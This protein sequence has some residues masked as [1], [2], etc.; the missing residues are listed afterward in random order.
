MT[1]SQSKGNGDDEQSDKGKAPTVYS[2]SF[3]DELFRRGILDQEF[4]NGGI[5]YDKPSNYD[6]IRDAI[7]A[8]RLDDVP[9]EADHREFVE[10]LWET[11][12]EAEKR[13]VYEMF[14]GIPK[15]LRKPHRK[16]LEGKWV[17]HIPI[18]GELARKD[19]KQKPHPDA[20]E[21]LQAL[22]IPQWILK[23][24]H[25][26]AVPRSRF[27]FPNFVVEL[28][29][30]KSMF[31]AHVQSRHCG[32]AA[33]QGFVEFYL[34]LGDAA[35]AWDT[36]KVGSIEFNGD[37]VVGNIHWATKSDVEPKGRKYHMTKAMCHFT[38]GLSF[39]QFKLARRE[40]RNF[41]DYFLKERENFQQR[42]N[43]L[44]ERPVEV[45]P[46]VDED[47]EVA[48][49]SNDATDE[50]DGAGQEIHYSFAEPLE[51]T[52]G[53]NSFLEVP[54]NGPPRSR[55]AARAPGKRAKGTGGRP[56][57]RT[58]GAEEKQNVGSRK[59]GGR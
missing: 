2:Q 10:T 43:S 9:S 6:T 36:A 31:T 38:H 48:D 41:R 53:E 26:Y 5:E 34:R 24:L 59:K 40:A 49:D 51:G 21:G 55:S 39:E 29:R 1:K 46:S 56:S 12:N 16:S 7:S 25:G 19:C 57:K 3:L 33:M 23:R 52:L 4:Q 18:T 50:E 8:E 32:A 58:K 28:K 14:F 15:R 37:V 22:H 47:S 17:K 42:C 30:D 45:L 27:A 20:A 44:R 11:S 35:D 13:D 54:E